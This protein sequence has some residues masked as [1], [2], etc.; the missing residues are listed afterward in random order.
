MA[1]RHRPRDFQPVFPQLHYG[2]QVGV[3][4]TLCLWYPYWTLLLAAETMT[5]PVFEKTTEMIEGLL[6]KVKD[7]E[8]KL[9]RKNIIIEQLKDHNDYLRSKVVKKKPPS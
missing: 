6:E 5:G 2:P 7:L 9:R 3:P 8:D 4:D 1:G